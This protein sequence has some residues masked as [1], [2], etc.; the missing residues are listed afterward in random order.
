MNQKKQKTP[1]EHGA[2]VASHI[3]RSRTL[4][5]AGTGWQRRMIV[6]A[7]DWFPESYGAFLDVWLDLRDKP[8][9]GVAGGPGWYGTP[10]G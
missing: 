3:A 6:E 10:R 1:R 5:Q 8:W 4:K 7:A 2:D 9:E